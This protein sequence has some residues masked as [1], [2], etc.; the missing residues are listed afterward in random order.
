MT[1]VLKF[2]FAFIKELFIKGNSILSN[3]NMSVQKPGAYLDLNYPQ[4]HGCFSS[5]LSKHKT[6]PFWNISFEL[7]QEFLLILYF[8]SSLWTPLEALDV[9]EL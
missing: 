4:L 8:L 6:L 2:D 5:S 3:E 7:G 1:F 9:Y